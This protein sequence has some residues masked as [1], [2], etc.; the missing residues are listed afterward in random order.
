M[1][2]CTYVCKHA[3]KYYQCITPSRGLYICRRQPLKSWPQAVLKAYVGAELLLHSL[4]TS[5]LEVYGIPC[6]T[7]LR[8]NGMDTR[9]GLKVLEKTLSQLHNI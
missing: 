2:V 3:C 6:G 9:A 7:C 4:I 1:Y 5:A 8:V